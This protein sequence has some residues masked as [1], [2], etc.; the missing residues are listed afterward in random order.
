MAAGHPYQRGFFSETH[1]ALVITVAGLEG[2]S[3]GCIFGLALGL[4]L[5]FV[6][7]GEP[8]GRQFVESGFLFYFGKGD[9]SALI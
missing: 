7:E 2:I 3:H 9:F 8:V 6:F 1:D 4:F 5:F